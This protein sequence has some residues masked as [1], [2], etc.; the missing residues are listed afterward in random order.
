MV[1]NHLADLG[2]IGG[3]PEN[4]QRLVHGAVVEDVEREIGRC[5]SRRRRSGL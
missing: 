2:E 5:S 1:S 3:A 4:V